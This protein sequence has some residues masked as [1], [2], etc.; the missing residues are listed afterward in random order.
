[1]GLAM[2]AAAQHG[3]R[4]VVLDRPNPLGGMVVGGPSLDAGSESFVGFHPMPVRHGMT[5][6]EL[7]RMF[8]HE[9]GL[10]DLEL[11]V[12]RCVGWSRPLYFDETGLRWVNPSPNMRN[13]NEAILYPGIGLWETTNI[14]VGRGTD[15]P[16]EVVGAPWIQ[17]S[18]LATAMNSSN[19]DG[20]RFT[21]RDFTPTSSK[22]ANTPCE[23]IQISITNRASFDPLRCGLTLACVLREL[24]PSQWEIEKSMRLLCNQTVLNA[25]QAGSSSDEIWRAIQGDVEE[26]ETR[27][28]EFLLY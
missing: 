26:F 18:K 6:G 19:L 4:F 17:A 24:Y 25:L 22:F 10:D 27:R 14:S 9:L 1:M 16:F 3:K 21:P 12:V 5:V 7:A 8:Q 13:L 28:L 11:E 20:V 15:T 23:G 2:Q